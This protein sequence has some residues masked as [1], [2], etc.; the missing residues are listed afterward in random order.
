[1]A[2]YLLQD[3]V[4]GVGGDPQQLDHLLQM[5]E[6][7]ICMDVADRPP[8]YQC[9]EGHLLCEECNSRVVDCPQCGHALMNSRNRTAEEL[10]AR[11]QVGKFKMC[12]KVET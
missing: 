12:K 9:P 8:I 4:G 6:C 7:P 10:A 3:G 11:L 5:L 2:P 1:M